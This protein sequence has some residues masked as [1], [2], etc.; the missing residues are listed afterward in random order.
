MAQSLGIIEVEAIYLADEKGTRVD[1]SKMSYGKYFLTA[2]LI[3]DNNKDGDFIDDK[4]QAISLK[5]EVNYAPRPM[6]ENTYYLKTTDDQGVETLKPLAVKYA[7]AK[8]AGTGSG[9][10][11]GI[12]VGIAVGISGGTPVETPISNTEPDLDLTDL[13]DTADKTYKYPVVVVPTDTYTYNSEDQ[14]PEIVVKNPSLGKSATNP[15]GTEL[16]IKSETA[17]GEYTSA[18]TAHKDA[19]TYS[20]KITAVP[21]VTDEGGNVTTQANYTG[22][23][24]VV[25]TIKKAKANV[26]VAAKNNIVYDG[27]N[28]DGDDFGVTAKETSPDE[29]TKEFLST[30][31]KKDSGT[32]FEVSAAIGKVYS[33]NIKYET[34][35]AS[36]ITLSSSDESCDTYVGKVI[37]GDIVVSPSAQLDINGE[38]KEITDHVLSVNI[39]NTENNILL[40]ENGQEKTINGVSN[41]GLIFNNDYTLTYNDENGTLTFTSYNQT[42]TLSAKEGYKLCIYSIDS[43]S[44]LNQL[45]HYYENIIIS[46]KAVPINELSRAKTLRILFTSRHLNRTALLTHLLQII[47]LQLKSTRAL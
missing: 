2:D 11:V 35:D 31:G 42:K 44:G 38:S 7:K 47:R 1:L 34:T 37:G 19:G 23:V 4:D 40:L 43:S 46:I 29:L 41:Y 8:A 25:W 14:K 12:P 16:I 22:D 20:E 28:L 30:I 6:S 26:T 24:T 3:I 9:I 33:D 5:R 32:T 17:A 18:V 45:N 10:A 27:K 36:G 21:S 15:D 13:K 39:D